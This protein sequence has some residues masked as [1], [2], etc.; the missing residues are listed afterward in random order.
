MNEPNLEQRLGELGERTLGL[1][2][3]AG[4]RSRVLAAVAADAASAFGAELLR[5]ARRLLPVGLALAVVCVAFAARDDAV[6]SAGLAAA[7][8]NLELP[9]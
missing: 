8:Q 6:S 5:S 3:S 4:F 9:W 2:A 7:E 1:G